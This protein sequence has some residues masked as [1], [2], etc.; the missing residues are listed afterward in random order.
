M[1]AQQLWILAPLFAVVAFVYGAVGLGGGSSY[2]ALMALAGVE[3]TIMP[4]LALALNL[5]VAGGGAWHYARAGHTRWRL[6]WPLAVAS[7]P[8]AWLCGQIVLPR[9]QFQ[10][11]LGGLL[12]VAAVRMWVF[13]GTD[14]RTD[15]EPG[16][17]LLLLLGGL[18]GALAGLTGIGGG[19]YLVPALVM[20]RIA[21][22]RTAA[23]TGAL[24]IVA[25]SLAGLGGRLAGGQPF[26]WE[27]LVPLAAAVLL[28]GQ[29]GARLGAQRFS[30]QTIRRL[31]G[32]LLLFVGVRLLVQTFLRGG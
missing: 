22:P 4:P 27:A 5:I 28:G 2:L 8:A 19:I 17:L 20:L 11:L 3:Y 9:E 6:F 30:P 12:V 15:R 25:N 7:M 24:F 32:V 29:V 13:R 26:P 14:A 1:D 10:F 23:A 21:T 16:M 18:L 31:F